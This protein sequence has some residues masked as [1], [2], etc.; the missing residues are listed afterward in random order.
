MLEHLKF[1]YYFIYWR[2]LIMSYAIIRNTNYKIKNLNGIYRHIERKN[3]HY[4]NKNINKKNGIKN[5]SLKAPKTTYE[6]LFNTI[7]KQYDLKGQIKKVSN[8]ACEYIITSDKE[9]FDKKG[10]DGFAYAY[11]YPGMNKVLQAA[12]RV[13]RTTEDEGIILLLDDRFLKRE[14]LE[15]FPREWEHFQMVNRGNVGQCMEDFWES[16]K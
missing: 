6:K 14:Y 4:S 15:L 5:Y 12:G 9:Y 8:V 10:M 2:Y 3:T 16:R 13:I 11:Q 1:Y 7:R